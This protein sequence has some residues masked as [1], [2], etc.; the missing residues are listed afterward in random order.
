MQLPQQIVLLRTLVTMSAVLT[1]HEDYTITWI[2]ALPLEAAASK[3]MFDKVHPQLSQSIGDDNAYTLGEISGHNIVMTCLP[4]GVYGII[5]AATVAAHVR[6]TYPSIRFSLM[7][8][9]GGGVPS[10][11]ND[12]RLGDIVVSKPTDLGTG[13]VHYDYGKTVTGGGFKQTGMMN[14]P[15]QVLLNAITRLQ[16]DEILGNGQGIGEVISDVLNTNAEMKSP[17]SRPANE[18]DRLFNPAYDHPQDEDTCIKC[19]KRQLIHRDSRTSDEPKI[20]YGLIASGNQ[21]MKDGRTRDRLAKEHGMLCFEMEAAGLMNQLPC[22]AIRGICDYS[23]SHKNKLWQG[24]AALTAAAYAKRLVKNQTSQNGC[25]VVPFQRNQQFLGRHNEVMELEQKI[26]NND[27]VRKM[28][29][30]G[31]GGVGKTQIAL[32]VC[33][34]YTVRMLNLLGLTGT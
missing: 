25:W 20:H 23:D 19:D 10:T 22:L 15:P 8:G 4:L 11:K 27:E 6:I 29:I 31:L 13:V 1:T 5:S 28:A 26:L 32:E 14:Q 3:M 30:A 12:I 34:L 16:A 18:P 24:Y 9:I 7:V 2:C 17:F 33:S 21:V